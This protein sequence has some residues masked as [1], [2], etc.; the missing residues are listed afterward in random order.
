MV[1]FTRFDRCPACFASAERLR[2]RNLWHLNPLKSLT[3]ATFDLLDLVK[4]D[5]YHS[6]RLLGDTAH[7]GFSKKTL[8]PRTE[9][10]KS[11]KASEKVQRELELPRQVCDLIGSSECRTGIRMPSAQYANLNFANRSHWDK[12]KRFFDNEQMSGIESFDIQSIT[13]EDLPPEVEEIALAVA[14][15]LDLGTQKSIE[16][17]M[18]FLNQKYLED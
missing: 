1:G 9:Y 13:T 10:Q 7:I 14:M 18:L 8:R 15:I 4:M 6:A 17:A 11:K 2:S 5:D 16:E 12:S 3:T